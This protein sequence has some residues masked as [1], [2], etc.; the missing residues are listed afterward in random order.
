MRHTHEFQPM[1][2]RYKFDFGECSYDNGWCQ[3]DTYQDAPYFG[4]WV[5][6]HER[7]QA[8]YCEGDVDFYE[9]DTDAEFAA[10]M[11]RLLI[12]FKAGLAGREYFRNHAWID[13][14]LST[15]FKNSERAAEL[16]L[17]AYTH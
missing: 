12:A 15:R 3:I 11:R 6:L 7:K 17:A 2:E 16:G 4:M 13:L 14:G 8:G 1:A 9:F 5:N 10:H